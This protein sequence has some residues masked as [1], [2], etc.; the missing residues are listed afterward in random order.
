MEHLLALVKSHPAWREGAA[1][2]T[3]LK[4]LDALGASNPVAVKGRKAL[5]KLLF[6]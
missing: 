3:L 1:K 6:R 2:A 5:S 4:L